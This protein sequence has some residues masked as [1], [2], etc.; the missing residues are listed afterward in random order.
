MWEEQTTNNEWLWQTLDIEIHSSQV[1]T[2]KVHSNFN[3]CYKITKKFVVSYLSIFLR[4]EKITPPYIS[5]D[6][7]RNLLGIGYGQA[8]TLFLCAQRIGM[9]NC[10]YVIWWGHQSILIRHVIKVVKD[11]VY[12]YLPM[13]KRRVSVGRAVKPLLI[14]ATYPTSNRLDSLEQLR[15]P[16]L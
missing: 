16:L 11:S 8:S 15:I 5:L 9:S 7:V 4:G 12:E 14:F 3:F 13:G 1:L 6:L 2:S 10:P